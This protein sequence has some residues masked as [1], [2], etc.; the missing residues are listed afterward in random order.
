[1]GLHPR[2][3]S[4]ASAHPG[5]R[6]FETAELAGL[7][8]ILW[9]D[10]CVQGTRGGDLHAELDTRPIQ[11]IFR[12]GMD[13]SV[14]AYSAFADNAGRNAT[15]LQGY[16]E[17]LGVREIY[18]TGLALDYCVKSTALDARRLLPAAAVTVVLDATRPVDPKTGE[19]AMVEIQRAGIGLVDSRDLV[20]RGK[21]A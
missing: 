16:L 13:P 12:K 14:D 1:M 8:Q 17:G 15:G 5:R 9:P 19:E 18:V 20:V 2:D 10:H 7:P 6:P 11:A 21:T 3:G 4:F